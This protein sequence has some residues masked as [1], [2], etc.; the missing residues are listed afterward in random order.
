MIL[1]DTNIFLEVSLARKHWKE[2]SGLADAITNGKITAIASY[3]SIQSAL[4]HLIGNGRMEA[5]KEFLDFVETAESL[6]IGFTDLQDDKKII[7]MAEKTHLDFDDALQY[8]IAQKYGA[9]AIASFDRHFD[10]FEIKRKTPKEILE[11][12]ELLDEKTSK[13]L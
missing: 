9:E 5:A 12:H 10:G 7:L 4:I 11:E 13:P 6:T 1:V 2:C 8:Y 3:F